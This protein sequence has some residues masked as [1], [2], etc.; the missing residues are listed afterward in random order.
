MSIA[1]PWHLYRLRVLWRIWRGSAAEMNRRVE[2]ENVLLSVAKGARLWDETEL[3]RRVIAN[4]AV[5]IV[6]QC[7]SKTYC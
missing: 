3:R 2:V 7:L 4:G 6:H 5:Q 1:M